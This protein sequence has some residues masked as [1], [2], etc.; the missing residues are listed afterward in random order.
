MGAAREN[1]GKLW[2]AIRFYDW[3]TG[4]APATEPDPAP[5][6]GTSTPSPQP[7]I[8]KRLLS[9]LNSR[10][11]NKPAALYEKTNSKLYGTGRV[12]KGRADITDWYN[13]LF[14]KI[15]PKATF[16]YRTW[17]WKGNQYKINWKAVS[18]SKMWTGSDT[19]YI[20]SS[21]LITLHY[22]SIPGPKSID[23]D[24]LAMEESEPGPIP[25]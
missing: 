20:S 7:D 5:P 15:M 25:V 12:R 14:N 17:S 23:A 18:G 9:A 16:S 19:F 2:K 1:G 6:T 10:N 21:N 24:D 13:R 3:A 4:T 22:T 8:L 11:P